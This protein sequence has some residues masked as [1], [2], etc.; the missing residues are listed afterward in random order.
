M[1]ELFQSPPT[2]SIQVKTE[3]HPAEELLERFALRSLPAETMIAL[4][5]HLDACAPC[6]AALTCEYEFIEA[7]RE[8]LRRPD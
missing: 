1:G 8:A 2:I 6:R 3:E 4:L 5:R 7:I